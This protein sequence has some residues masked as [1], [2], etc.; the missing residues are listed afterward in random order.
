ML[1]KAYCDCN[2]LVIHECLH[3][4]L[5]YKKLFHEVFSPMNTFL[6]VYRPNQQKWIWQ[7]DINILG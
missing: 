2:K 3:G 6:N 4:Q 5:L 7:C 1:F